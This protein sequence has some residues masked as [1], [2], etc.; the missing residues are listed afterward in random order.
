MKLRMSFSAWHLIVCSLARADRVSFLFQRSA[1]A[2]CAGMDYPLHRGDT[3]ALGLHDRYCAMYV[4]FFFLP[5]SLCLLLLSHIRTPILAR[6]SRV[7]RDFGSSSW[8]TRDLL[9]L[10]SARVPRSS[11]DFMV[12]S[13]FFAPRYTVPGD[14]IGRYRGDRS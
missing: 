10:N 9:V 13:I 3:M 2:E 12:I 1:V 5:L 11:T 7:H 4:F 8:R 14:G 6:S